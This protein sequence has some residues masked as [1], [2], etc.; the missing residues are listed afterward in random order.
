MQCMRINVFIL[1]PF[2]KSILGIVRATQLV[3]VFAFNWLST[4]KLNGERDDDQY[5]EDKHND[6]ELPWDSN[7]RFHELPPH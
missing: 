3:G 2:A 5:S 6:W 4:P 1:V 7:L